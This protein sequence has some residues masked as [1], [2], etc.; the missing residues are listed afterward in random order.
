MSET[1]F[2]RIEERLDKISEILAINTEQLRLHI[3]RT[4][5]A[6]KRLE[7]IESEAKHQNVIVNKHIAMIE[8]GLKLLGLAS[9]LLG[10][11]KI[12]FELL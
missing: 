9:M 7:L 3:Y 2:D 6:E 11:L 10:L 8:G 5:L 4:E 12:A 1:R